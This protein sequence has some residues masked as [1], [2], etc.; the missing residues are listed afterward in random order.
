MRKSLLLLAALVPLAGIAGFVGISSSA[1]AASIAMDSSVADA[2][3][4]ACPTTPAGA[5][6]IN[7]DQI[8]SQ[9]VT[10]ALSVRG[11]GG[12]D[13][14]DGGREGR[15]DSERGEVEDD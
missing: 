4:T 2:S 15:G 12:D 6:P 14:E 7:L 3:A 5:G 11:C 9:P 8:P 1:G 13:D 10:G